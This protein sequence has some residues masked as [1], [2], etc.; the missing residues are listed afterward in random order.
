MG[1]YFRP[2]PDVKVRLGGCG[3][4]WSLGP[5]AAGLHADTGLLQV[6]HV[7]ANSLREVLI[8]PGYVTTEN[9]RPLWRE[10]GPEHG[11]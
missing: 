9:V 4:R 5:R 2:A 7:V 6:G 11:V 1:V 10:R 8:L 3:L